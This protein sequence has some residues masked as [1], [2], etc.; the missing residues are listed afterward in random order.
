M[1]IDLY[2]NAVCLMKSRSMAK[3]ACDRGKITL[4]GQPAK[5]SAAVRTGD[6]IGIDLTV[7]IMELKVTALPPKSVARKRAP[8][9]YDML[10]DERPALD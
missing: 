1:R 4:N 3:E 7:R 8:E 6:V 2:L 9:F 10:R 5:A